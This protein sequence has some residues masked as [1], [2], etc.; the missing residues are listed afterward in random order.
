LR[1]PSTTC[2]YLWK[3]TELFGAG[4]LRQFYLDAQLIALDPDIIHFEFGTIAVAKS[5]LKELLGCKII[6]SF[7]GYDL[8]FSGLDDPAYYERTW[9]S[10]DV[11]HFLG[12]DLKERAYRR[13]CPAD[14][15]YALIP[16]A[17]D[18]DYYRPELK[19]HHECVGTPERPLRIVSVGRLEWKKGYEY[20]LE[21]VSLLSGQGITF[22]YHII[23]SGNY[24]DAIAFARHQ[25]SVE[26]NVHLLG[27]LPV[28]A[29]RREM[30]WAD[31]LM[32]SAV[33]EGFCNAVMEAQAME[34][35]IVCTNAD[36]LAENVADGE[37]GF[38]VPRRS[39]KEMA[40]R[41]SLLAQ[42]PSLRSRMGSAG[43]R[44]VQTLF[45]IQD[46]IASFEELYR[47]VMQ[48]EIKYSSVS[49]RNR[50]RSG[51]AGDEVRR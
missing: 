5:H 3:G 19:K 4:I 32:H 31:V 18:L 9:Q 2:R 26:D 25:L 45:R 8:N 6:A 40:E 14:K 10:V 43:R 37:S 47:T 12:N 15:P 27:A 42:D 24:T 29:V 16:P 22:E 48:R 46:Q 7:R 41:L 28:T 30:L 39:P 11:A 38:V 35:P 23:G 49:T 36:G 20:G 33:S 17:I 13:G 34:L 50:I 44:R 51:E 1:K 21:A